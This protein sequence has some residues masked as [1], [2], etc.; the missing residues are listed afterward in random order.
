MSHAQPPHP[1]SR[2][3]PVVRRIVSSWRRLTGGRAVRDEARPTLVACS[4]GADSSALVLALS[5]VTPRPAVAHVVHDM[6]SVEEAERDLELTADLC[7]H[8]GLSFHQGRVEISGEPGNAEANARRTRYAELGLLAARAGCAHV[9]TAHHADDQLET[10]LMRL[11]RGTG[12]RG[13]AGIYT[14]R[15][16]RRG[17]TLVRP[18]LGVTRVEALEICRRCGWSWAE[19]RTN[20]DHSRRRAALRERVLPAL[21]E[22]EPASAHHAVRLAEVLRS[23]HRVI[24][25]RAERLE[26]AGEREEDVLFFSRMMLRHEEQSVLVELILRLHH[27]KTG[28]VRRDRIN[29]HSLTTCIG[30]ICADSGEM[31]VFD[32]GGLRVEVG[33]ARVS[34][35]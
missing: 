16:L 27:S 28:G 10:V 25:T 3:D 17:V 11:I 4:G 26:S 2:K 24:E 18:M 34:F 6:R 33:S 22:I 7:A 14:E 5:T 8:L 23:V 9:A 21:R 1:P 15:S 20:T 31:R 35:S 19:D 12:V 32:L 13:L 30:A 29:Y